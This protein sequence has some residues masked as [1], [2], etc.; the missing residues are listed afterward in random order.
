[1][2]FSE[3]TNGRGATIRSSTILTQSERVRSPPA[4]FFNY[5]EHSGRA[6][7]DAPGWRDA[8]NVGRV[9]AFLLSD[10][11]DGITAE[12]VHV[13]YGYTAMGSPGRMLDRLKS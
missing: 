13:D 4:L 1:M 3:L 10:M 5:H 12:I 11:S 6:E 2:R 9:G 8:E 7:R